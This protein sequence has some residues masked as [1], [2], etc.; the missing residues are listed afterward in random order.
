MICELV[1]DPPAEKAEFLSRTKRFIA[2]LS[3]KG[4]QTYAF[5]PHT[6]RLTGLLQEQREVLVVSR[7]KDRSRKLPWDI[8]GIRDGRVWVLVDPRLGNA[9]IERALRIHAIR[10]ISGYRLVTREV[11][12]GKSRFDFEIRNETR[13]IIEVKSCPVKQRNAAIFPDAPSTRSTHHAE[14]L[15]RLQRTGTRTFL[16]LLATR[17]D[18]T[19]IR[20]NHGIDRE[21]CAA[22]SRA[23]ESGVQVLGLLLSVNPTR[24]KLGEEIPVLHCRFCEDGRDMPVS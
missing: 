24:L 18:V 9:L 7:Q 19:E 6:G 8:I 16:V 15:K 23:R 11:A 4:H 14:M 13:S 3:I 2:S 20:L 5:L 22:V 12:V 1:L 21:F 10:S 17:P